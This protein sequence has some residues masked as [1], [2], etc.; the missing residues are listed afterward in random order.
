LDAS[1]NQSHKPLCGS[2]PGRRPVS[3]QAQEEREREDWR[4]G[5]WQVNDPDGWI[6]FTFRPDNRYIAKSGADAV[7]SRVERGQYLVRAGKITLAPYH[8]LGAARGFEIDLYDG[9]LFLIGDNL[10]MVVARKI[11]GSESG[12]VEKTL[13]PVALEGELG[14]IL[15]LWTASMPGESAE[16]VFRPD[17]QFRLN[18][19]G[20][21]AVSQDYGLFTVHMADRTLVYDSRFSP[22]Q[23]RSLDF[24]GDTMTVFGGHSSPSTYTVNLGMADAAISASLA[25]DDAE[26]QIDAQ[27]M[28]RAPVLPRDPNAV[29]TPAGNIPPDP[30]PGVIFENAVVLKQ[31]QLYRRL[32]PGFVQFN[33]SGTIRSVAVV[34]TREWHLFP[35]GRVMVRF[36]NHRAGLVYP[37]TV[38]ETSDIWGAYIVEPKP[39][40]TDILHIY[41]DN[42]LFM[43]T[44]MGEQIEMTLEDGRRN[45]FWGKD[46]LIWSEW[47]SEQKPIPCELPDTSDPSLMN[48]GVPLSTDIPPD[49]AQGSRPV[50][51]SLAGP[52]DG[53]VTISGTVEAASSLITDRTLSLNLPVEWETVQ[54]NNVSA[55]PFSFQIPGDPTVPAAYF[56]VR[57]E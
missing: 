49:S 14:S 6:E 38:A 13:R 46:Y 4:I 51:F 7:P 47:A 20:N 40:E 42:V 18:R 26:A 28:E 29:H 11:P 22:V 57:A 27:W 53:K 37:V 44:D 2:R 25:A 8:G 19:C 12:V 52:V 48:T 30:N 31:Y 32:I 24:Y 17:G 35:T 43:E 23:T 16:L 39:A 10:R 5:I 21:G 3:R 56:R 36:T 15:G 33:V 50:L 54:T 9:E 34:N 41:A 1:G 45:L 55:G